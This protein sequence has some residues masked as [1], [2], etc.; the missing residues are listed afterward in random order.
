MCRRLVT[1][2]AAVVVVTLGAAVVVVV[3]V[4]VVDI[5][6]NS[7]KLSFRHCSLQVGVEYD[8]VETISDR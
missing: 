7:M 2:A 4:V 3:V 8:T 1:L 5:T 6:L